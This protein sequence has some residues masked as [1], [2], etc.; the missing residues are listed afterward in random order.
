MM[1]RDYNKP[2]LRKVSGKKSWYVFVTKP[3]PLRSNPKD[4]QVRRSTG[5]SDKR[6]A[7]KLLHS[8]AEQIY[9][10]FDEQ[11]NTDP[12]ISF[13]RKH[14]ALDEPLELSGPNPNTLDDTV[15]AA[16]YRKIVICE[17]VCFQTGEFNQTLAL[18]LFEF[19]NEKEAKSWKSWIEIDDSPFPLQMRQRETNDTLAKQV[20]RMQR[21]GTV[22]NKTGAPSLS[23][24]L[25]EYVNDP[26]RW[27]G[28]SV[29][30]KDAQLNRLTSVI[31]L[32]G[33]IP[34]DQVQRRQDRQVVLE[35][36]MWMRTKVL[37]R[38]LI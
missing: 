23:E 25:D 1:H 7:E 31:D 3:E 12:F 21:D 2:T 4:K 22:L 5:T 34:V 11:L 18:Q 26:Y 24:I 17:K 13:V 15:G 36:L 6:I 33:D 29:K 14:W 10:Q 8:V 35:H 16:D 37:L 9:R 32:I 30:E 27:K 38:T 28:M 19:L 20:L